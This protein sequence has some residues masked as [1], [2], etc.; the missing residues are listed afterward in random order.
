MAIINMERNT[1]TKTT[2]ETE[3]TTNTQLTRSPLPKKKDSIHLPIKLTFNSNKNNSRKTKKTRQ[4]RN[5]ILYNKMRPHLKNKTCRIPTKTKLPKMAHLH[6]NPKKATKENATRID[7]R[8]KPRNRTTQ[9][10]PSLSNPSK[11]RPTC[12][13]KA[14]LKLTLPNCL[15]LTM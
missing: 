13:L 9:H 12:H 8:I 14:C 2:M 6:R 7:R 11:I 3:T 10:L 5:N 4:L 1:K 15:R